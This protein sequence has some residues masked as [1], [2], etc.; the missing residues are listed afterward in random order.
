MDKWSS[1]LWIL[2]QELGPGAQW[3][4]A[5]DGDLTCRPERGSCLTSSRRGGTGCDADNMHP[6]VLVLLTNERH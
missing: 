3:S 1:G 5:R 2:I 4:P 6:L